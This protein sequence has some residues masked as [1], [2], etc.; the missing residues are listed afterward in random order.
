MPTQSLLSRGEPGSMQRVITHGADWLS[1]IYPEAERLP[2]TDIWGPHPSQ[3]RR[4][5]MRLKNC[6]GAQEINVSSALKTGVRTKEK[7]GL[8]F[9]VGLNS[10]E[11][12]V[13]RRQVL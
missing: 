9:G 11:I 1:R 4:L 7:P 2:Y 5:S 8:P 12:L 3:A 6:A 10:Q 13:P